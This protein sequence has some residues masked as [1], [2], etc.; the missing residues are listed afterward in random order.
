M[1]PHR[2]G[3]CLSELTWILHHPCTST[4]QELALTKADLAPSPNSSGTREN[5]GRPPPRGL[6]SGLA[7][8]PAQ[9]RR[10]P[11]SPSRGWRTAQPDEPWSV[12]AW[13][14]ADSPQRRFTRVGHLHRA[15]ASPFGHCSWIWPGAR[16]AAPNLR[17]GGPRPSSLR[18]VSRFGQ[19]QPVPVSLSAILE[20]TSAPSAAVRCP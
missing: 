20:M 10:A 15:T 6:R 3:T 16:I 9:A 8:I 1:T 13:I 11:C 12:D 7:R 19:V 2:T 4:A 5:H 18:G 17:M 14:P